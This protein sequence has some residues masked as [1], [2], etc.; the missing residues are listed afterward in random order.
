[1]KPS[2]ARVW[3]VAAFVATFISTAAPAVAQAAAAREVQ[4]L[5]RFQF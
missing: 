2:G 1:M 5:L 3:T 4:L